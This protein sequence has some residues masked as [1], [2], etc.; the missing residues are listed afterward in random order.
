MAYIL[1]ETVGSKFKGKVSADEI[2]LLCEESGFVLPCG[3]TAV[4]E[5]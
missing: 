2:G 4:W 5:N 3:S 1:G